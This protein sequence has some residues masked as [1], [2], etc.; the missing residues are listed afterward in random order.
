MEYYIWGGIELSPAE[1]DYVLKH[2]SLHRWHN[3]KVLY[4]K[5]G[6]EIP[7]MWIAMIAIDSYKIAAQQKASGEQQWFDIS[8]PQ[9]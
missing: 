9:S 1:F 4:T 6:E 8:G 2:E 3:T 7:E 5:D